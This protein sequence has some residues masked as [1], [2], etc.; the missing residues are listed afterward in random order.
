MVK[1]NAI[2]V[3]KGAVETNM[4]VMRRFSKRVSGAGIVRASRSRRYNERPKSALKQK[5]EALKRMAKK[6][7]YERLKKLGKIKDAEYRRH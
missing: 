3:V 7:T 6:A 5:N 1:T 2:E 4:S